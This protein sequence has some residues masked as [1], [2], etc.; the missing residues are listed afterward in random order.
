MAT[1]EM[2]REL[3]DYDRWANRRLFDAVA[4]LPAGEAE[5]EIGRQFSFP[6]LKGMLAHILGALTIWLARWEGTSPTAMLSPGEFP[7]LSA[8]RRRWDEQD[9]KIRA[10][11]AGLRDQDLTRVIHYK[12]TQGQAF[13]LPLWPLMQHVA[14]H[15][16]HH[17]SEVA[18]MLT[19]LGSAPPPTDLVVYHLVRSGQMV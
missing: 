17:R 3:Y 10:F 13:Q 14:N 1:L 4:T 12:N 18:T 19:T 2:I 8:L 5:R 11:I 9:E 15:S 7:D 6:T 16:T